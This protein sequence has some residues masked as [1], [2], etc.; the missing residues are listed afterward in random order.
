MLK[1]VTALGIMALLSAGLA[2]HAAA[3]EK[4]C[5]AAA[6]SI[7]DSNNLIMLSG[8]AKGDVRLAVGGL[9]GKDLDE[10]ARSNFRFDACGGL[11]EEAYDYHKTEDNLTLNMANHIRRSDDGGW[12][13]VYD[14]AIFIQRD[15]QQ[16]LVNRKQG[17]TRFNVG[18]RGVITSATDVFMINGQP[19]FTATTFDYDPHL[20]LV[21]STARGTDPFSNDVN[22]YAYD[23]QGHIAEVTSSQG[24]TTFFYDAAGNE[25]GA[26]STSRTPF[27]Q[28]TKKEECQRNDAVGNCVLSY[29]REMEIS[30]KGIIFRH[31]SSATQYQYWE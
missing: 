7:N 25:Q 29:G 4:A 3:A 27:S 13:S 8:T 10:Q 28:I 17:A 30:A 1:N 2:G 18:K 14:L 26:Y 16:R 24:K 23:R 5:P 11:L 20:R 15:G 6:K 9:V 22:G 19:G 12:E 31:R 21:Q